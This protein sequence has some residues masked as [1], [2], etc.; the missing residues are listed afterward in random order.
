MR[1]YVG[2]SVFAV[3]VAAACWFF[4]LGLVASIVVALVGAAGGI[5]VSTILRTPDNLNW[6]PAPPQPSDGARREVWEFAWAIRP[7]GGYLDDR[8]VDRLR[9][10]AGASLARRHLDLDNPEH[11]ARIEKLIGAPAYALLVSTERHRVSFDLFLSILT[12]LESLEGAA[13]PVH[14]GRSIQNH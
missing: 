4:G 7:R 5:A 12:T 1:R 14:A 10:I 8:I 11:R 13:P 9:R 3:L 2:I 6:P